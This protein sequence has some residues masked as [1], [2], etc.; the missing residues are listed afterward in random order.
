MC[1][2]AGPFTPVLIHEEHVSHLLLMTMDKGSRKEESHWHQPFS[3]QKCSSCSSAF[4]SSWQKTRWAWHKGP[5][6]VS[7]RGHQNSSIAPPWLE[8]LK[9]SCSLLK[10]T[11]L[12]NTNTKHMTFSVEL[13]QMYIVLLVSAA[14]LLVSWSMTPLP[15]FAAPANW[16]IVRA[17]W[18]NKPSKSSVSKIQDFFQMFEAVVSEFQMHLSWILRCTSLPNLLDT[19]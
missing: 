2:T 11:F 3:S 12:F 17:L 13:G 8:V 5:T 18:I 7:W 14:Y 9:A 6:E 1:N 19:N 10:N 16:S 4:S 15:I